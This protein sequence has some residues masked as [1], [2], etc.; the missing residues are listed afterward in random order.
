MK[1]GKFK[2]S[3][4]ERTCLV[5][6]RLSGKGVKA[7]AIGI[8]CFGVVLMGSAAVRQFSHNKNKINNY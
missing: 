5:I 4:T 1:N 8:I 3:K 6:E 7:S 2:I